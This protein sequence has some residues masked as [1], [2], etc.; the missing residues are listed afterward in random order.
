[1]NKEKNDT[2]IEEKVE[3][4]ESLRE[5]LDDTRML[6]KNLGTFI[7]GFLIDKFEAKGAVTVFE[8]DSALGYV[9]TL[10]DRHNKKYTQGHLDN[11][12]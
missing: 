5:E 7:E 6:V 10:I 3:E 8:R 11:N 9:K 12:M 1:M 2:V 4:K